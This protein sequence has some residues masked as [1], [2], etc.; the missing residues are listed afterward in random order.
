[1]FQPLA[2]WGDDYVHLVGIGKYWQRQNPL[3][4]ASHPLE[5]FSG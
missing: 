1:M 5:G 4:L 2:E 3:E